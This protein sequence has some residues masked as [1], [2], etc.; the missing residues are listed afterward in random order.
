MIYFQTRE[1]PAGKSSRSPSRLTRE[2]TLAC[3]A[4]KGEEIYLIVARPLTHPPPP[5]QTRPAEVDFFIQFLKEPFQQKKRLPPPQCKS[6]SCPQWSLN[7]WLNSTQIC[8]Q[9]STAP[10]AGKTLSG[11]FN[12]WHLMNVMM[13]L[14]CLMWTSSIPMLVVVAGW[15][16]IPSS[17]IRLLVTGP[18]TFT[19]I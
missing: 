8:I 2:G 16:S 5:P 12:C 4:G 15:T 14:N 19:L 13:G 7:S 10:R 17:S 11:Y 3:I 1:Q 9:K 18:C 6:N